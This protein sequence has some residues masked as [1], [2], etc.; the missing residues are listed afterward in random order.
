MRR[1]LRIVAP[2]VLLWLA[3]AAAAACTCA[4]PAPVM[5]SLRDADA[6][7]VGRVLEITGRRSSGAVLVRLAVE[8]AW[9]GAES[10]EIL[11]WTESTTAACGYPFRVGGRYL[12][13]GWHAEGR[14][15]PRAG[16]DAV[17]TSVCSR[18]APVQAAQNDLEALGPPREGG[19]KP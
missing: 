1:A 9:K 7:F 2:A 18:T 10:A 12:V 15:A 17:W 3:P 19:E 11:V 8:R 5:E 16:K 4:P 6:V 14:R 13:Y